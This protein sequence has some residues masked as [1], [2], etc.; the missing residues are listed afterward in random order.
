MSQSNSPQRPEARVIDP[1][2]A[3]GALLVIIAATAL[4]TYAVLILPGK[5]QAS[6]GPPDRFLEAATQQVAQLSAA[7][8]TSTE[9]VEATQDNST[10]STLEATATPVIQ[11]PGT[12][13]QGSAGG[14]RPTPTIN[15]YGDWPLRGMDADYWLSIPA[16]NLEAPI[17]AF[18]PRENEIDG[19]TVLRLPV[20]NSFAASWD[21]RSAAPGS[22][23]NTVISGHSNAY[24]GVF[25]DLDQLGIGAEIALWSELGVFSYYISSIQYVEEKDVPL[26]QRYENARIWLGP[27]ADTRVTL[28]TCWPESDSSMRLIIVANR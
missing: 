27:S 24:G 4:I 21:A 10:Q 28:I 12:G 6:E 3:V 18:S 17:V 20:P 5:L 14:V 16:I 22:P 19:V 25:G 11:L 1:L 9:A 13:G 2:T 8:S 7:T 26:H 15:P 23:G